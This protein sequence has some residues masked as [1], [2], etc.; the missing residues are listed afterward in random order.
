MKRGIF[1]GSFDPIHWGHID[2]I[3]YAFNSR[4]IDMITFYVALTSPIKN[5]WYC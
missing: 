4:L 3:E 5:K 2:P 1:C